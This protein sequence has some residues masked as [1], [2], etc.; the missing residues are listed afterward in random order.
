MAGYR[1]DG[2]DDYG[3]IT[4]I[5]DL[6]SGEVGAWCPGHLVTWAVTLL[7]ALGYTV[8]EP[9][10]QEAEAPVTAPGEGEAAPD[11]PSSKRGR[12]RGA[13]AQTALSSPAS[14]FPDPTPVDG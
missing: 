5:T 13:A 8:A 3:P 10:P 12:T 2:D 9:A 1:C 4:L 6:E 11:P 14:P 7:T